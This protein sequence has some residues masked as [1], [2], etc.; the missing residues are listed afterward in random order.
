MSQRPRSITADRSQHFLLVEW[1]DGHTSR[2]SFSLLRRACPCAVCRGG[3]EMMGLP[4]DE[5]IFLLPEEDSPATRLKNI[6]AVGTYALTIEWEDG[7]HYGI[8]QW[9]FLRS[10]CPC[11]Q[12]RPHL[13]K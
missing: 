6:E 13:S 12:C 7:H 1:S 5:S 10:L 2:Y 11:E 9:D 4:P 3:H 8:Y